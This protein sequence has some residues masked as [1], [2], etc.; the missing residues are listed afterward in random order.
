[1]EKSNFSR[2]RKTYNNRREQFN[3]RNQNNGENTSPFY[4]NPSVRVK[5]EQDIE[6]NKK[7]SI[8]V[9]TAEIDEAYRVRDLISFSL[10]YPRASR[11]AVR[12]L[13]RGNEDGILPGSVML[14][15]NDIKNY[16]SHHPQRQLI[17]NFEN[18]II[19]V[20]VRGDAEFAYEKLVKKE[21]DYVLQV[22]AKGTEKA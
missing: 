4:K 3:N 11:E 14:E 17:V 20:H 22:H 7:K 1:M 13:I 12:E 2:T 18:R 9:V 8:M 16:D 10:D 19:I 15:E 5:F 6:I 21:N